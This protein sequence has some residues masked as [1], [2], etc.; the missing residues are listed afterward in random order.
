MGSLEVCGNSVPFTITVEDPCLTTE[1]VSYGFDYQMTQPQLQTET[2]S[3]GFQITLE[4]G[5]NTWGWATQLD[6]DTPD[7]PYGTNLCGPIVYKVRTNE[8]IPQVTD[9]VTL[10]NEVLTFAPQLDDPAGTV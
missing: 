7:S 8:S 5:Q 3:L 1:I 4:N 9:L 2:L 10:S 6:L